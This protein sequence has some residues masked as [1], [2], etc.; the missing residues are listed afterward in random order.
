MCPADCITSV[1]GEFLFRDGNHLRRNL[2]PEGVEKFVALL[3]LPELLRG[4][5]DHARQPAP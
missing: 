3:G 2:S 1:A 5:D 4:L